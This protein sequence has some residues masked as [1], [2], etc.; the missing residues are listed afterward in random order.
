M[1]FLKVLCL[2]LAMAGLMSA[3]SCAEVPRNEAAR[4]PA[5]VPARYRD[6]KVYTT[7]TPDPK[8]ASHIIMTLQFHNEGSRALKMRVRLN[9]NEKAGFKGGETSQLLNPKSEAK[10]TLDL[11]PADGLRYEVITGDITFGATRER[12]LYIAVQGPDPA[13]FKEKKIEPITAQAEVVGTYAP[14]VQ[15]NW[16]RSDPSASLQPGRRVKPLLT[17]AAAGQTKYRIVMDSMPR[18]EDGSILEFQDWSKIKAPRPGEI[19]FIAAVKDLQ[20]CIQIMSGAVLPVEAGHPKSPAPMIR[21]SLNDKVKW[22]HPDAY[23]IKTFRNDMVYIESGHLDGLRQGIYRLLTHHLDCH[24]FMPGQ[25]GEE[26]P[27]PADRTVVIGQINETSQPTFFSVSGMSWGAHRDWDLRNQSFINRGRMTFGHAFYGLLTPSEESFK[28]HPDWWAR[29]RE[30]KIRKFERG[31]SQTNFCTTSPEVIEIVAKKIN[32]QL[33][34]PD[35]LVAS[36]DPNDYGPMCLCD[37]CLKLDAKYGVTNQDGTYVTDRLLHFSKEIYDRLEPQN[38]NKYLGILVYAYQMELPKSAVPHAHHTG[39]VCNMDWEY[40]H[41]RPFTD[42]TSPTNRDF[43]RLLKGWGKILPQFGFYD[44]YGQFRMFG[45]WGIVHKIREDLP[46]FRDLG[47]TYL[48]IEAQPN[49]AINGLNLYIAARLAWDVDA[50]V[51][52]L[53]EEYFTKFYGPAAAPMRE[54]WLA[55]ERHYAL[56]RSGPLAIERV[57]ARPEMWQELERHL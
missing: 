56:T 13:G 47:G 54:Y 12:E 24:W 9:A 28:E 23:S 22:P 34:N 1:K 3:V 38:K 15:I 29:D 35:A 50:D 17:L 19:E 2:S 48:M 20:R 36:L 26:I 37:R 7:S 52:V 43:L 5:D 31:W 4:K 10:W 41:T 11:R 21:L 51:D 27:R 30:G 44:Y 45:P 57:S 18:A 55:M 14:R 40:D 53:M 25:L 33:S 39:M 32:T 49:F 16:W 46:A 42:P 8:D 6:F